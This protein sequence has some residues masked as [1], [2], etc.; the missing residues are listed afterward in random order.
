MKKIILA[1]CIFLTGS[2]SLYSQNINGRFSSSLY[3][4]ERFDTADVSANHLRAFQLLNLNINKNKFALRTSLNFE[5]DLSSTLQYDPRLRF[6]NLYLEGRDLFGIATLKLGR[7][8]IFS[9]IGGGLFDGVDLVLRQNIFRLSAFYGGNVPAYQKLELIKNWDDNFIYGG[10]LTVAPVNEFQASLGYVNKNYRPEDYWATRLDADF[11]PMVVLIRGN[12][13]QFRYGFLEADYDMKNIFSLNTRYEYDFNFDQTSR[14]EAFG[15]Y[16]QL[17]DIN[18]NLY[19]NYRQPRIRYNSIFSVFDF[20]NTQEIEGGV[21]YTLN[22]YLTLSGKYGFVEYRDDNSQRY[23]L[24]VISPLGTLTYRK[25][26]GYSGELDALSIYTAHTFMEGFITPLLGVSY[27]SYKLYQDDNK[28]DLISVIAGA[29]L[30]P[31]RTLS[32]D[33]QGQYMNNKIYQNDYR[34][35]FK[36][37]YWFNTNLNWM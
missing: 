14:V 11:N 19:Y 34:L 27:A 12:S 3:A 13:N 8:P 33:L 23:S 9:N 25:N 31:W 2:V 15:S 26:L 37:N 29:N 20:G 24:G 22:K 6:Y 28:N 18:F 7:Q 30:R 16:R 32:F 1:V 21:D 36:I 10:R 4:Y 17:K 35:F 5:T